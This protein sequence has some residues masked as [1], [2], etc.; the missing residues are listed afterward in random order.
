MADIKI[1]S[2]SGKLYAGVD[3]DLEIYSNG[4]HSYISNATAAHSIVLRTRASGGATADAVTIDSDKNVTMVGNIIM[5]DDTSIGISDSDER[6]E[7]DASGDISVLGANFGI[8]TSAPSDYE[9]GADNLVL[10]EA[11]NVG[12]TIASGT[13]GTGSIYFADG[14]SGDSEYRGYI[15]YVH[16]STDALRFGAGASARMI[17][18]SNSRISLSNND[19]GGT[20]GADSTSGNTFFGYLA[21][22]HSENGSHNNTLIGHKAAGG[23]S[24]ANFENNVVIGTNAG[25]AATEADQC[26]IIGQ[27][28]GTAITGSEDLV[29]VGQ[30]AGSSLTDNVDKVVFIGR[31]AG[32]TTNSNNA[33]GT[34]GIGH[35]ALTALTSGV[36]NVAIGYQAMQKITTGGYN[37]VVGHSAFS[38]TDGANGVQGR[39]NVHIGYLSGGGNHGNGL[40]QYNTVVGANTMTGACDSA[41]YNT[42]FGY[43]AGAGIISAD[44]N[45]LIGVEAGNDLTT[46]G[47]NVAIGY[48]ALDESHADADSN[49]AIGTSAMGG[50]HTGTRVLYNVAIGKEALSGALDAGD[51]NIA[52]GYSAG[53]TL[54]TGD[55]NVLIGQMSGSYDGNDITLGSANVLIGNYNKVSA[56]D[57]TH[58]VVLGYYV[59]GQGHDTITIGEGTTDLE[60]SF[61]DTSWSNPSDVRYKEDIQDEVVGLDFIND[62]R[63]VT[64]LWKKE[65]DVPKEHASYVEG[66]DKRVMNGKYNH[67]FIA[68]EVKESIDKHSGIKEGFSLWK[69]D[70]TEDRQRVAPSALIPI[71]TKAV[72]ELSTELEDLKKKV[73]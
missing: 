71:L 29:L 54:T 25:A 15:Q 49:I 11:V 3:A 27:N 10:Y 8:G 28:A 1:A 61:H 18:D 24:W 62:L 64:Y 7:F 59:T 5:A 42:I 2:D 52:I 37:T 67:G 60:C 48:K 68:Q 41:N 33:V 21:G 65:K 32:A 45:T 73:G 47:D 43:A 58:E 66:S 19:S 40:H 57:V 34:V 13:S 4:S 23:A 35:S 55:H 44:N 20:S 56:A 9:G 69:E 39:F 31:N 30:G 36:G 12:M 70:A 26:V 22:Q 53:S 14:T 72:Q 6:I 51:S 17:L 50:T 16:A 63:P 46:G 38:D